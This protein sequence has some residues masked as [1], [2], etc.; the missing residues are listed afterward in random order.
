MTEVFLRRIFVIIRQRIIFTDDGGRNPR[1]IPKV[2]FVGNINNQ[3][4]IKVPLIGTSGSGIQRHS[5]VGGEW[6]YMVQEHLWNNSLSSASGPII[7]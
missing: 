6:G 1:E 2:R 4:P 5:V 3:S 7:S